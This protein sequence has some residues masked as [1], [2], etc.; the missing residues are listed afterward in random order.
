MCSSYSCHSIVGVVVYDIMY[1]IIDSYMY[2]YIN[3]YIYVYI[4]VHAY[5]LIY[6][7]VALLPHGPRPA[8][9]LYLGGQYLS[10]FCETEFMTLSFFL[11]IGFSYPISRK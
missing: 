4:Y 7:S 3:I 5:T 9:V 1:V 6:L 11:K 8:V 10:I 2:T